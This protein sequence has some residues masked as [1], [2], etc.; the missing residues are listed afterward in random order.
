[1]TKLNIGVVGQGGRGIGMMATLAA[2][3]DVHISAICDIRP[4]CMKKGNEY[5]MENHG[6][7]AKEYLDFHDLVDDKDVDAVFVP[8]AWEN[9]VP[10]A[11]YAMRQGKRVATEVGGACDLNDCWDLV[12]TSEQTGIPF[13]MAENCCYDVCEQTLLHMTRQGLFGEL[14]YCTGGYE[15]CLQDEIGNGDRTGHYRQRH[16]L[17]RC[18]DNYPTHE[19][20]PIAKLLDIN[21][22]N[23]F[24][25]LTST[26]TKAVGLHDYWMRTRPE[27]DPLRTA[28]VN[29]GDVIT[30]V[31]KCARGENIVLVLDTTLP[32]PYSRNF[33]VQ[34]TR[35]LWME[36]KGVGP[37]WSDSS[38]IHLDGVQKEGEWASFA[39]YRDDAGFNPLWDWYR[40]EGIRGG[41][42]GMDYLVLRAFV[43]SVKEDKLPPIDVYD[44][45]AWMAITALSEQSIAQGSAPVAVPDF[46]SGGWLTVKPHGAARYD[47]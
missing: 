17:N 21:N 27:G 31:I 20:G 30:T 23:R 42:G 26:S 13:M 24:L 5:L 12:R 18:C 1:M 25:S 33:R 41:H 8:S 38:M 28:R 19:L 11:L 22:G 40:R 44:A 36:D 37:E 34:G 2:M 35:G 45:A 6:Y 14:V 15:H 16:Y 4:E 3:E 9:H 46:T 29:Q 32:R 39:P 7:T 47:L 43:E 10:T